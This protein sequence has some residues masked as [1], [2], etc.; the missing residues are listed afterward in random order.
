MLY[1]NKTNNVIT[2]KVM[3]LKVKT[4]KNAK[5]RTTGI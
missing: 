5:S 4:V 2:I 1:Y 3:L